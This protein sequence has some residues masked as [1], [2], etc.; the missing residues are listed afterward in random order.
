[1]PRKEDPV[2]RNARREAI[3]IFAV[4]AAATAFCCT[5]C[6]LFG[7]LRPGRPLGPDDI[8]P[9]LGMPRWFF[10]GVIVP[11]AVC[12]AFIAWFAGSH[13]ADDDLGSDHAAEL[14]RDIREG[15]AHE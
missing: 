13:M 5:Y 6:Y 7:Y 4:W 3:L 8:R 2:L 12:L 11:W 10:G 15:A 9:I 1:L 14:E